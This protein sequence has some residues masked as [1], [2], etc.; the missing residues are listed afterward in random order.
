MPKS[1][2]GPCFSNQPHILSDVIVVDNLPGT[3]LQFNVTLP[4]CYKPQCH[5]LLYNYSRTDLQSCQDT[6]SHVPWDTI[7]GFDYHLVLV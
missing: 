5:C 7:I 2:I 4:S 1:Y 3:A 6:L